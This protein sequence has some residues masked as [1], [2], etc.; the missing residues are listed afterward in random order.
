MVWGFPWTP[1]GHSRALLGSSAMCC[2]RRWGSLGELLDDFEALEAKTTKCLKMMTLLMK[3][4]GL[5]GPKGSTMRQKLCR[6]KPR[7]GKRAKNA[8]RSRKSTPTS[9]S[10]A[11]RSALARDGVPPGSP[12]GGG[13]NPAAGSDFTRLICYFLGFGLISGPHGSE[14]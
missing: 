8:E 11:L 4:L 5:G 1:P 13:G 12:G 9:V 6:N 3:M 10:G 14:T 7:R 2:W